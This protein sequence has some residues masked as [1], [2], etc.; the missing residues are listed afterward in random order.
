MAMNEPMLADLTQRLD[1][2]ERGNRRLR[3]AG[4]ILLLALVAVGAMGQVLPKA[5]PKVVEAERFVVRDTRGKISATLGAGSGTTTPALSLADQ[6]GKLRA[7]LAVLSDGAVGLVLADKDGNLRASI[8]LAA[9]AS[10]Q[11][12]LYNKEGRGG[13]G[14]IVRADGAGLT[15]DDKDGERRV[16]L[17]LNAYGFPSLHL[18]DKDGKVIWKAP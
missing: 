4:V 17:G 15:L 16:M 9:D 11:V 3:L 18:S 7:G 12:I 6:N 13:A 5:V 1:R 8:G 14:L 2:L 10:S